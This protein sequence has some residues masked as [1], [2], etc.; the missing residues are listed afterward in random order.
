MAYRPS[1]QFFRTATRTSLGN[2]KNTLFWEDRWIDGFRLCEL[3]PDIYHRVPKRTRSKRRVSEALENSAWAGDIGPDLPA[4]DI[5][6]FLHFRLRIEAA[7]LTEGVDDS[8]TW[9]WEKDGRF[10]ARS[11]YAARFMGLEASPTAPFT[12]RSR[13]PLQCRFFAWLAIQ[14]RC[15]TSDRLARRGLPHQDACPFCDQHEESI[16]HLLV[17]C[18]FARQVWHGLGMTTGRREFEPLHDET[19]GQWCLRQD[20]DPSNTPM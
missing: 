19:L 20:Q 2:G 18:V 9:A 4:E 1:Q 17:G 16:H 11:A 3:A 14:D 5:D 7:Q 6:Q 13:A 15:W 10:S 8:T 12:W